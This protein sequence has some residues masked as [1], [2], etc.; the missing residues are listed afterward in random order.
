MTTPLSVAI[1]GSGPSGC[2]VAQSLR[3]ALPR[4]E[5]TI[6][7]RLAS[8]FGLVRYGVAPDHQ[9]TK[10]IQ[11]QFARLFERDDVRFAG[12]VDVG[13]DVSLEQLRTIHHVV[14]L[15]AGLSTDRKLGIPGEDLPEVYRAGNLTRLFNAHPLEPSGVPNLG[16]SVVI[17][18]GGNVSI[19]FL[20]LLIKQSEDFTSS[21]IDD[22]ALNEYM[23]SPVRR[24]DL[25][26]RAT[27]TSAP[28][29]PVMLAELG[30]IRGVKFACSDPL[31]VADEAPRPA[32][33]RAKAVA[34]LLEVDPGTETRVEVALHFGWTPAAIEGGEHVQAVQLRSTD[35]AGAGK[36]LE[37]DSLITAIG[38]D[39]DGGD[40]HGL[41]PLKADSGSG[42]LGPGLYRA[43]WFKRGPRGTIAE[44]RKC[45]KAVADEIIADLE[46]LELQPKPGYQGLP[47]DVR[48]RAVGYDAW[49]L[50][51]A[52]ELESAPADRT[53][54]K[55]PSHEH[56]V[57]IAQNKVAQATA[58][59][60]PN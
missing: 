60:R 3:R 47:A 57:A 46:S 33:A 18:G 27:V 17:I 55:F 23:Q 15:A 20:R 9:S 43:G 28:S 19:N 21:D 5:I 34:E 12:N 44:N 13:T 7:D 50:L 24:V 16:T 37:A 45:A 31:D 49:K 52:A 41:G 10:S 6:Y 35:S 11:A 59:P 29:D 53:R 40:W 42:V 48:E 22:A 25:I 56:M 14:V 26:C 58:S 39:F 4:P 36:H 38:F 54:R 8:P 2:Y 30:R 32:I 1:V 51:E